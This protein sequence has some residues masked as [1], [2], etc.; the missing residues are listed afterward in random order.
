MGSWDVEEEV[1]L[2][3][4]MIVSDYLPIDLSRSGR[5]LTDMTI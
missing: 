5:K 3:R 2:L 4:K 1:R